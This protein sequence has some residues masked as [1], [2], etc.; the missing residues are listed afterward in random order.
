MSPY[1]FKNGWD[2][3]KIV[4]NLTASDFRW[5]ALTAR[6]E[7]RQRTLNGNDIN[8]KPFVPYSQATVDK[9]ASVGKKT[10]IVNLEDTNA[11][12]G[13]LTIDANKEQGIVG[14]SNAKAAEYGLYHQTG[15]GVPKREW[16]GLSD[17]GL[18]DLSEKLCNRI[19][20]RNEKKGAK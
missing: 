17:S 13:S 2:M 19:I 20:E 3:S 12:L 7:I 10:D 15:S 6:N 4:M 14:L 8:G 11:M 16:F 18:Q 9:R 5:A 1:S